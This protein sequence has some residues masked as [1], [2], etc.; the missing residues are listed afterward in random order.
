MFAT[1]AGVPVVAFGDQAIGYSDDVTGARIKIRF[2]SIGT[3][4]RDEART[5]YDA[6]V[7]PDGDTYVDPDNPTVPLGSVIESS[8]SNR[9]VVCSLLIECT[10]ANDDATAWA[11]EDRIRG[12]ITLPSSRTALAALGLGLSVLSDSRE[13]NYA[14]DGVEISAVGFD[15]TFCAA[16]E[17]DDTPVTTIEEIEQAYNVRGTNP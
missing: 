8:R 12:K 5:R 1:L 15:A 14:Y 4:G 11:Y 7:V 10:R 2:L 16:T 3:I 17:T 13:S 6:S 9:R